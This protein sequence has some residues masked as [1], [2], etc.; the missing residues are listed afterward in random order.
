MGIA[1]ATTGSRNAIQP[2]EGDAIEFL[3]TMCS[4]GSHLGRTSTFA[5]MAKFYTHLGHYGEDSSGPYLPEPC[6]VT[7]NPAVNLRNQASLL[8]E[9]Y[10]AKTAEIRWIVN[11]QQIGDRRL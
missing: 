5:K 2:R 4:Q 7:C 10:F 9:S 1:A 6:T 11:A 3:Q 8:K